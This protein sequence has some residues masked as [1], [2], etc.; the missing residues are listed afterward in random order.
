MIPP[1]HI[2]LHALERFKS[3]WPLPV[4]PKQWEEALLRLLSRATETDIGAGN[5]IRLMNH[6]LRP[7]RYFVADGWRFITDETAERLLTCERINFQSRPAG[8]LTM[9]D[10]RRV[11]RE[12]NKKKP[13][14]HSPGQ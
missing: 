3:R 14:G 2:T 12:R 13:R 1:R 7:A 5:A 6:D 10:R 8:S 9:K 11:K 4:A